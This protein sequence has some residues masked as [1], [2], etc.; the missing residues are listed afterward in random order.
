M[1]RVGLIQSDGIGDIIIGLPIAK[2]FA[3]EGAQVFWPINEK[4]VSFF[5][6]AAPYVTFIPV[7]RKE[8]EDFFIAIPRAELKARQCGEIYVLYNWILEDDRHLH[9]AFHARV[10]GLH[11]ERGIQLV[12]FE[13]CVRLLPSRGLHDL[14]R[15]GGRHADLRQQVVRIKSDRSE[16]RIQLLGPESSG[17]RRRRRC[18]RHGCLRACLK[19]RERGK[20]DHRQGEL[21]RCGA[22]RSEIGSAWCG[23]HER[24]PCGL[25]L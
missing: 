19:G 2:A 17:L 18:L 14:K 9:Q 5:T 6:P 25:R 21:E 11:I 3:D 24:L 22:S 20:H 4:Y 8:P 7:P 1:R 12:A 10:P 15:V 13:V 16:E 23:A